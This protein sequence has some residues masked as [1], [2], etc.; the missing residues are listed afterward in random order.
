M[1]KQLTYLITLVAML[2]LSV[3]AF[4]QGG[5]S[6]YVGSSHSYSVTPGNA[7]NSFQWALSGGGTLTNATSTTANV[8]WTTPGTYTL[9]FTET[10]VTTSCATVKQVPITVTSAFDVT[11]ASV[12]SVCNSAEGVVNFGGTDTTTT[13]SY[14]INMSTGTTWSPDW[15]VTFTLGGATVAEVSND[16]NVVTASGSSYT[17]SGLSSTSGSGSVTVDVKVT[18]SAFSQ[19]NLLLTITDAEENDFS[20]TFLGNGTKSDTGVVYAIPQTSPIS[21]N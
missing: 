3:G 6:P 13:I 17:I 21:A 20:S 7:G 19:Q 11:L 10:D 5:L 12:D 4:A 14:V 1:K 8:S 16:G 2:V 18:G 15:Q 9:T